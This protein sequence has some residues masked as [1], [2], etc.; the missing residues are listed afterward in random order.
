MSTAELLERELDSLSVERVEIV[1]ELSEV[2]I[3]DLGAG[4]RRYLMPTALCWSCYGPG[5]AKDSD[6]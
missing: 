5:S 6:D 4:T 3:G 2:N 1:D